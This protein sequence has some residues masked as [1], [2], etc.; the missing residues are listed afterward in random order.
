MTGVIPRIV[1]GIDISRKTNSLL[2]YPTY[3]LIFNKSSNLILNDCKLE[4]CNIGVITYLNAATD[5]TGKTVIN[6]FSINSVKK[7]FEQ[8]DNTP[9]YT[10]SP[11]LI[12]YVA[13]NST[14]TMLPL[15]SVVLNRGT[16]YYSLTL[17]DLQYEQNFILGLQ[18]VG[19]IFN[20]THKQLSFDNASNTQINN[21]N[22][23][24]N[25]IRT[26]EQDTCVGMMNLQYANN[27]FE[28]NN[29]KNSVGYAYITSGLSDN[30]IPY[31]QYIQTNGINGTNVDG[32]TENQLENI[33]LSGKCILTASPSTSI[34]VSTFVSNDPTV[35]NNGNFWA[36]NL[37]GR[38]II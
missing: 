6:M 23:V 12:N 28:T 8:L 9:N 35:Y 4:N 1:E 24:I 27:L 10:N 7:T 5:Y 34:A 33:D 20:H 3:S 17:D 38:I 30:I 36:A 25:K 32:K 29:I 14:C 22:N 11:S 37:S 15:S 19:S 18:Q 16:T 21:F 26:Y 2:S 31:G 13:G